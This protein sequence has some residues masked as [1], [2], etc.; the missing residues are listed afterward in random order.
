MSSEGAV[1]RCH[2]CLQL[3]PVNARRCPHCGDRLKVNSRRLT[4]YL[5]VFGIVV[6]LGLVGFSLFL[7]PV[8]VDLDNEAASETPK[9]E[10]PKPVKKPPLD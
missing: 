5:A 3:V 2:R 4:L 7:K 6:V 1:E 9:Q 8:V 10:A